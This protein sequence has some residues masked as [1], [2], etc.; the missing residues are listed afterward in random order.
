M[1]LK[2]ALVVSDLTSSGNLF[3]L[4][5]DE[6]GQLQLPTLSLAPI[7]KPNNPRFIFTSC[8]LC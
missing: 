2:E 5:G 3:Q 7:K 8:Y 4:D 6:T 1:F